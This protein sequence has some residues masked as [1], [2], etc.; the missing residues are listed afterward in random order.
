MF[1]VWLA[2]TAEVL[3]IA[4]AVVALFQVRTSQGAIA[5][6][7][8]LV[9]MPFLAVPAY[10]VFGRRRFRGYVT[11]RRRHLKEMV[12]EAQAVAQ[13]HA[14]RGVIDPPQ[15]PADRLLVRLARL[16]FTRGNEA[17][18]LVDGEDTFR[19]LLDGIDRAT[20]YVLVQ[21]YILRA[22]GLGRALKERLVAKAK[23]GVRVYVLYDE[24]GSLGLPRAYV[25]ELTQTGA[26]VLPFNTRRGRANRF[27]L[28]FR[29]H[30]KLVIVDGR[31]AWAGGL[32]VGDEYL[33]HDRRFG[34]W[35]DTHVHVHG[36]AVV[37]L[38][39]AFLEDWHWASGAGLELD[40]EAHKV[41]DPGLRVL[42]LPTGP[43]DQDETCSLF[44]TDLIHHA[45]TRLW[46]ASPYFVPDDAVMSA[47]VIAAMRGVDVRILLPE[48]SDSLLVWLARHAYVEACERA[49]V[50]L[51]LYARG[52]LH[53]KVMVVDERFAA[54]G[55]ANLDN[56]SL[57]LNFEL[58]VLFD[59]AGF[60]RET[61]AML[62]R[63]FE[64]ATPLT[65]ADVVARGRLFGFAVRLAN[66]FSPVL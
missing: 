15:D 16:P 24:V 57:R 59:D 1:Y 53:Q 27:Q 29:N 51:F 56:R 41:A 34:P 28:N 38:Q 64:G 46:I 37:S 5:W 63:D 40:W 18:L 6:L 66:L 30:R 2:I 21:F 35:R 32:N 4:T 33:G 23:A 54:V 12:A 65:Y 17:S 49:G 11:A 14:S 47:L 36:P 45:R 10:W 43:A 7:V 50:K 44:F 60:A 26:V 52:F 20:R 19:S 55:T 42:V 39:V 13:R 3:G 48:R 22:D 31:E 61:G 8:S 25:G 58:T 62:A 9:A